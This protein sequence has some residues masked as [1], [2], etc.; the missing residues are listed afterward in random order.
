MELLLL[1]ILEKIKKTPTMRVFNDLYYMC[2][3]TKKTNIPLATKY[4]MLL[5]D[6]C[7]RVIASKDYF[8]IIN[9]K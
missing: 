8:V 4:L 9:Y 5:S 2:L 6:E 1:T 3:E 7:E